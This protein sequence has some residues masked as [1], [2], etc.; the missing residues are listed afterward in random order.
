MHPHGRLTRKPDLAER[1]EAA[2]TSV[3]RSRSWA[4]GN[5]P[6]DHMYP[7][8]SKLGQGHLMVQTRKRGATF[9]LL[10][11]IQYHPSHPA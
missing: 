2:I 9:V 8:V 5:S 3:S 7:M 1:T 4:V 6:G 11:G 10:L